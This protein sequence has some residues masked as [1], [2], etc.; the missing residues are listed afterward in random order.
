MTIGCAGLN[1]LDDWRGRQD[2]I[3][4]ELRATVIAV[5]DELAA[6][7]DLARRKD[8]S[9]PAV[10]VRGA[11]DYVSEQDGPGVQALIRPENEDL[12]R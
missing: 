12:F 10:L 5:A 1:P 9:Q 7:A 3:G 6:A 8:R 4:R 11:E 2:S